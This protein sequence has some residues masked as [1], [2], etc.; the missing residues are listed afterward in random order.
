MNTYFENLD[1]VNGNRITLSYAPVL[2]TIELKINGVNQ[3]LGI[4]Y[5]YNALENYIEYFDILDI[6]A[7]TLSYEVD[8]PQIQAMSVP[9]REQYGEPP[10]LY[11][12]GS[13]KVVIDGSNIA[14]SLQTLTQLAKTIKSTLNP[15]SPLLINLLTPRS[16]LQSL[17]PEIPP[18]LCEYL[19]PDLP[20]NEQPSPVN[21]PAVTNLSQVGNLFVP[22]IDFSLFQPDL[23]IANNGDQGYYPQPGD[24]RYASCTLDYSP[25][26]GLYGTNWTANFIDPYIGVRLYSADGEFIESAQ[27]DQEYNGDKLVYRFTEVGEDYRK[28]YGGNLLIKINFSGGQSFVIP[29]SRNRYENLGTAQKPFTWA[30]TSEGCGFASL[31]TCRKAYV[32]VHKSYLFPS[33]TSTQNITAQPCDL[34]R[35]VYNE[36]RQGYEVFWPASYKIKTDDIIDSILRDQRQGIKTLLGYRLE[37]NIVQ[38]LLEWD[39]AAEQV[40]IC[41]TPGVSSIGY[42]SFLPANQTATNTGDFPTSAELYIK[43]GPARGGLKIIFR[44]RFYGSELEEVYYIQ[45]GPVQYVT[46]GSP[47]LT[48]VFADVEARE[49]FRE[50]F[51]MPRNPLI[52]RF[53]R[54]RPDVIDDFRT[55]DRAYFRTDADGTVR[56]F[57]DLD[58]DGTPEVS[59]ISPY[60]PLYI[61]FKFLIEGLVE[62]PPQ[63]NTEILVPIGGTQCIIVFTGGSEEGSESHGSARV[64]GYIYAWRFSKDGAAYGFNIIVYHSFGISTVPDGSVDYGKGGARTGGY[65]IRWKPESE[66]DSKLVILAR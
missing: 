38:G 29:D 45:N 26:I 57:V 40:N 62:I 24:L 65:P 20:V 60:D 58:G 27:F 48:N 18:E 44:T 16:D 41:E 61:T 28:D 9:E 5:F 21:V 32:V 22:Q 1:T 43:E 59:A 52:D 35:V 10:P 56:F 4:D 47:V 7:A 25:D 39:A 8:E 30:P 63:F 11:P 33:Y 13:N 6:A 31:E 14:V 36:S 53:Q 46:P 37:T 50:Y 12:G 23:C 2:S 3:A 49:F 54:D 34:F 66:N 15:S 42:K 17:R 55:T 51:Y 64:N 19:P